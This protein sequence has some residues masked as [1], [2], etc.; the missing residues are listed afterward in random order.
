MTTPRPA[1]TI[2]VT[3]GANGI[4]RGICHLFAAR[5]W[6]VYCA[7]KDES[8]GLELQREIGAGGGTLIFVPTDVRRVP[9]LEALIE[10]AASTGRI[11][12]LVNNVGIEKY[13]RPEEFTLEDWDAIVEVNLRSTFLCARLALPHLA[14]VQGSIVNISSV[15]GFANEP[16]SSIYAATKSGILGL[17]RCL[18]VDFAAQRVRVNAVCPGAIYT[19]MTEAALVNDPHPQQTLD[20]LSERIPLGRVGEP[21]D[22]ASA[23]FFLA[24]AEASYITG[25]S[26]VV[27][28]GLL[29]RLAT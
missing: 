2:V 10:T 12:T 17:T 3:G 15:Q 22:V 13:A 26:L 6:R 20:E 18:A 19:A 1:Q 7:D 27:D 9:A 14:K 29:S 21:A 16:G 8:R 5:G 11:D 4:G 25:A 24:S 28:G 23:V